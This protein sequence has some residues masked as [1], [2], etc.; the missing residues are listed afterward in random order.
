MG[1]ELWEYFSWV[2]SVEK[3]V[4]FPVHDDFDYLR[5]SG[6]ER[7]EYFCLVDMIGENDILIGDAFHFL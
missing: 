2:H 5:A 7:L 6:M 3:S 4:D 1:R